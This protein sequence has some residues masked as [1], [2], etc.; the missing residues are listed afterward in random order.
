MLYPRDLV[1]GHRAGSGDAVEHP[2]A[3]V[4]R[5]LDR[6]IGPALLGRLRQSHQQRRLAQGQAAR[7]LAEIG[8]RGR[9][10]AFEIA[11]VGREAEIEGKD[12]VLAQAALDRDRAHHLAQL[13]RERA[14]SARL[15]QARHLHGERGRAG[16][17]AAIADELREGAAE[18]ERIDAMVRIEPL[19]LVGEQ[20]CQE[21][22]I[23]ML[24]RRRQPPAPLQRGVGPQQ[25][26]VAIDHQRR[27]GEP[28]PQRRRAEGG[29]PA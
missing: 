8:E 23:D 28:L 15:E 9:A 17:D 5:G 3:G 29:D 24:A 27:E 11:A 19:V 7:L 6:A 16:D 13:G 21:T 12:L 22:R 14:L 20:Q 4:A 26:A 2:V 1:Q 25:L 10:H 18:R